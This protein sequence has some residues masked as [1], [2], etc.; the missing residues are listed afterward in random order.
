MKCSKCNKNPR[1]DKYWCVECLREKNSKIYQKN[2]EKYKANA[3]KWRKNNPEKA[4]QHR[5]TSNRRLRTDALDKYGWECRC[6]GETEEKFLSIDHIGGGGNQ[7]R[8]QIGSS[9][10][11]SWL[12]KN[13][14]P[15]NFQTLCHNC[16]MA[17][18]FYKICPHNQ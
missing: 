9:H 17:K 12:R 14:Y 6:C 18:G 16:N 1:H 13:N 2:K 4:L 11:Y 5:R 15:N 8:R 10:I 7:H 3:I